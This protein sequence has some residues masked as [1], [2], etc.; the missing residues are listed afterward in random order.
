[1]AERAIF[2]LPDQHHWKENTRKFEVLAQKITRTNISHRNVVLPESPQRKLNVSG[3]SG[4]FSF[5]NL[6]VFFLLS[7][8]ISTHRC[9]HVHTCTHKCRLNI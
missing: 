9:M 5:V 6:V 8:M 4:M 3:Y 2:I 1:V 7:E